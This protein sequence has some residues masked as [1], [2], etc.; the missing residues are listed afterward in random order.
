MEVT[1]EI[2]IFSLLIL[3]LFAGSL[4]CGIWCLYMLVTRQPIWPLEERRPVPWGGGAT[5]GIVL[6]SF[7]TAIAPTVIVA[8][9]LGI[10]ETSEVD[11][12]TF[13]PQEFSLLLAT[14]T[15]AKV[16]LCVAVAG[17]LILGAGA[18]LSDLSLKTDSLPR[19]ILLGMFMFGAVLIPIGVL[20]L[21]LNVI[22]DPQSKHPIL[23]MLQDPGT[24]GHVWLISAFAA[25]IA[26]PLTE[27]FIFRGIVQGYLEKRFGPASWLPILI[28][29]GFFAAVHF[30]ADSP[31]PIPLFFFALALG[32]LY[33]QT[34]R[35]WPCIVLHMCLNGMSIGLMWLIARNPEL[36]PSFIFHS[37]F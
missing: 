33:R 32:Y 2:A 1:P 34:H 24:P 19:D 3:L 23:E 36:S 25:V 31:D 6:L 14:D 9:A 21:T 8:L 12:E 30:N 20:N 13:S 7:V 17:M 10:S 4:A 29:S 37:W 35:L 26:A 15:G 16:A 27:E 22:F 18:T 28:S 5:L 11:G